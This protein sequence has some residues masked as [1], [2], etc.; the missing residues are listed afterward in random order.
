MM[1]LGV[2]GIVMDAAGGRYEIELE[3]EPQQR[4]TAFM[5]EFTEDLDVTPIDLVSADDDD[6]RSHSGQHRLEIAEAA[7]DWDAENPPMQFG[8]IIIDKPYGRVLAMG[9]VSKFPGQHG[10]AVAS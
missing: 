1:V 9:V 8:R 3:T 4:S 7:Q 10:A 5:A 2:Q 6:F